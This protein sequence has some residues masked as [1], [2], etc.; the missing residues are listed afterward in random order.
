VILTAGDVSGETITT[1]V[2]YS[3]CHVDR[4]SSCNL[5]LTEATSPVTMAAGR[6]CTVVRWP[7]LTKARLNKQRMSTT[8][9]QRLYLG[10]PMV[11]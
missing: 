8:V 7:S 11:L 10:S 9:R 2:F 4:P 6:S 3:S 1:Y 5:W